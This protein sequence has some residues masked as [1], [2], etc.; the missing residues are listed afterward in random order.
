TLA[1]KAV[2]VLR[3]EPSTGAST[4]RHWSTLRGVLPNATYAYPGGQERVTDS[5][6]VGHVVRTTPALGMLGAPLTEGEDVRTR[7]VPFDDP[8]A[9]W[10]VL[11][12][13]VEV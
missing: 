13:T 1:A 6:V 2:Q 12:V 3:A 7:I 9:A 4:M 8:R 10:R 11:S 5:A